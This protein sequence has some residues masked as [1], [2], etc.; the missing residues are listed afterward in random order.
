MKV[1]GTPD[2]GLHFYRPGLSFATDR[3]ESEQMLRDME[4]E[5]D[6]AIVGPC[7]EC[8]QTHRLNDHNLCTFCAGSLMLEA[9]ADNEE[10]ALCDGA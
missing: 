10:R 5:L 6:A 7:L 4:R 3:Q 9:E 1:T 8:G 2:G